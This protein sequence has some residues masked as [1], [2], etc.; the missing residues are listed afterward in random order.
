MKDR[1]RFELKKLAWLLNA[2]TDM[3]EFSN[4]FKIRNVRLFSKILEEIIESKGDPDSQKINAIYRQLQGTL[5]DEVQAHFPGQS[6]EQLKDIVISKY[7]GS[8][9]PN[10]VPGYV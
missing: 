5:L 1:G 4:E 6:K 8:S 10:D 3:P 7:P 2:L 9:M